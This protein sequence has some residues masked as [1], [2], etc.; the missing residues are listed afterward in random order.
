MSD[1]NRAMTIYCTAR[2]LDGKGGHH[3]PGEKKTFGPRESGEAGKLLASNRWSLD[4]E[5]GKAA[6][7]RADKAK[8]GKTP[9][10]KS[11]AK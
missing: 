4:P 5:A 11:P 1:D 2:C 6:K 10:E 7:A 8:A 3:E 9:V